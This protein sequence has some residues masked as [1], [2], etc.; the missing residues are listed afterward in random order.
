MERCVLVAVVVGGNSRGG[1]WVD[2]NIVSVIVVA[3]VC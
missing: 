2:M 1:G 3:V